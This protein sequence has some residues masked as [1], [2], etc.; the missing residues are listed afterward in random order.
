MAALLQIQGMA[1]KLG[2]E[3]QIIAS[4]S[5]A[6]NLTMPGSVVLPT[7]TISSMGLRGEVRTRAWAVTIALGDPKFMINRCLESY[8]TVESHSTTTGAGQ[9]FDGNLTM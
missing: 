3:S 1:D 6:K 8:P 5:V 2:S 9:L 4:S 7:C